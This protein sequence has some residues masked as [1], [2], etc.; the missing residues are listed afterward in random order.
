[1]TLATVLFPL[2]FLLV[3][4]LAYALSA[5]PKIQE[6]GRITFFCGL[7]WLVYVLVHV[8]LHLSAS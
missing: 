2:A 6:M 4:A 7:F 5:N 1:M 8:N 3:G